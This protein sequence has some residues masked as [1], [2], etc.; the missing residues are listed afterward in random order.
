[1]KTLFSTALLSSALF[2]AVVG[3][4]LP[5]HASTPSASENISF[6]HDGY[7]FSTRKITADDGSYRL[8]G[9]DAV[10]GERY[11]LRVLGNRVSGTFGGSKVSFTVKNHST[12]R[13]VA[14][15]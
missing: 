10:T 3:V 4:A 1:M 14:I 7:Q 6:A 13:E 2:S 8:I 12:T 9:K 5:A 15:R 11:A